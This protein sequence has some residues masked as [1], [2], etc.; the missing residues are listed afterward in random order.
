MRAISKVGE[1]MTSTELFIRQ[2]QERSAE[3]MHA[4]FL[5]HRAE[6][7]G[8][9]F[10]ILRQELDSLVRVIYL[11]SVT[12]RKR[13]VELI[14]ASTEGRKWKNGKKNITDRE[15]VDLAQT[16]HGWTQS[17]Y[18]FGCGFIHLSKLHDHRHRDPMK[19]I[20]PA[21]KADIVKRLRYYHGGP[22]SNDPTFADIVPFLP[23]VFMKIHDNLECYLRS[24]AADEDLSDG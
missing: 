23:G 6:L 16:L 2:I 22:V 24:L 5:L 20:S 21:E 11:L 15:M 10:G 19:E 14:T 9:E 3:N 1:S 13:R 12:D 8:Q 4:I 7:S 17:V 18:L